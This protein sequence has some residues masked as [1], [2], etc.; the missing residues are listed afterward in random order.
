LN[1]IESPSSMIE[2]SAVL[3]FLEKRSAF[4]T[5][6]VANAS[7]ARAH[8]TGFAIWFGVAYF[9]CCVPKANSRF[10]LAPQ[11]RDFNDCARST[12]DGVDTPLKVG[13]FASFR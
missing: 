13:V 2:V 6:K 12:L 11:S 1:S 3:G 7:A 5:A 9:P 8:R 10:T 4:C